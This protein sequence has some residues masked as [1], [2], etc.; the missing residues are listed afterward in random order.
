MG[1]PEYQGLVTEDGRWTGEVRCLPERLDQPLHW[2][3]PARIFV[4]SMSDLFHHIIPVEFIAAVYARMMECTQH[5]FIVLTKRAERAARLLRPGGLVHEIVAGI[6]QQADL[7]W[8][9]PNVWFGV[10]VENQAAADER[11]PLLLET[12]A[13]VR[14]VSCEPLLGPVDLKPAP[15]HQWPDLSCW[16]PNRDE[17][18]DW[19]YWMHKWNGIH[20]VIVGGESGPGARPMA[21]DWVDS[22]LDQCLKAG[23]PFFFKQWGEWYPS[24][25]HGSRDFHGGYPYDQKTDTVRIGKKRSGRILDGRTWDQYP[26][27][28]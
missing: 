10:S 8:P 27:M 23:V 12:P 11:I 18:D 26:E 28:A 17:P 9:L 22:I 7:A 3:K 19:K 24:P 15:L 13:A 20:W 21:Y 16:M 25:F 1:R 2:K 6:Y 14:F 4:D 5:T